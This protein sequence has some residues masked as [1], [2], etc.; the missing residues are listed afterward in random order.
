MRS[1]GCPPVLSAR[2]DWQYRTLIH[3]RSLAQTMER[4]A[5][6]G[7]DGAARH[8][9]LRG[10]AAAGLRICS[11]RPSNWCSPSCW[12]PAPLS[13]REAG[14]PSWRWL[15]SLLVATIGAISVS[16]EPS[17]LDIN[18]FAGAWL[19]MGVTMGCVVSGAVFAPGRITYHRIMGAVL[20]YLTIA[21]TFVP[22][23][24]FV[25]TIDAAERL[26]GIA[27]AGY[28]GTR[29]QPDLL[30]LRDA[31]LDR[32]RRRAAGPPDRAQPVQRRDDHRPA[33]SA[34]PARPAGARW[35]WRTGTEHSIPV[36]KARTANGNAVRLPAGF[37]G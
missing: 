18:L 12:W 26:Y 34:D 30:Q 4:P 10:R 29:Q 13:C 16:S 27:D 15:A 19:V 14:L 21:V 33:L 2:F 25:E 24:A 28:A 11:S 8:N 37:T 5:A 3:E 36:S 32:L 1:Y 7:A 35:K 17:G 9:A 6:D 23:F 22:I 20:L 31:D